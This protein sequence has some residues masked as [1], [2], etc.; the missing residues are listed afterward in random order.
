MVSVV[1]PAYNEEDNLPSCLE[2]FLKQ[3]T[4][5]P[6]EV[7]VVDNASIDKTA[8]VASNFSTKLNLKIIGEPEKGRGAARARGFN[9]AQGDVVLS[10]DADCVVPPNWIEVMALALRSDRG[11]AVS[12]SFVV[13]GLPPIK[14]FIFRAIQGAAMRFYRVWFQHWWLNGFNFAIYKNAYQQAGGFK[15]E[16]N[17]Q[18]DIDLS[19][20]VHKLGR[21]T[22]V[23][24]SKVLFSSRR[25][26]AGLLKGLY[27][28]LKTFQQYYLQGK[29]DVHLD[30]PR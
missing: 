19:L 10:T 12:G 18:E 13:A 8:K 7:I 11:V 16:L 9:E 23:P 15:S 25:F 4:R 26:Q 3:T 20:R 24:Y 14:S 6:F 17:A 30:D 27:Q 22:Y 1:I 28:Y 5:E 2:A 29:N 21:I